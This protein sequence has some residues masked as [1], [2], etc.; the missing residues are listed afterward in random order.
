ML[1]SAWKKHKTFDGSYR[2]PYCVCCLVL[3]VLLLFYWLQPIIHWEQGNFQFL[4]KLNTA[5]FWMWSHFW[6]SSCL[7][8][9]LL[10]QYPPPLQYRLAL[11]SQPV[12][13]FKTANGDFHI[14]II[15][16]VQEGRYD[17]FCYHL[18]HPNYNTTQTL[19]KNNT[20]ETRPNCQTCLSAD[21]FPLGP[22]FASSQFYRG[23]PK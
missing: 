13:T 12:D 18:H 16:P 22:W 10:A 15:H 5:L 1:I 19:L 2:N 14:C 3:M 6:T 20:K 9:L 23:R 7:L 11:V 4:K 8:L 21:I 17:N